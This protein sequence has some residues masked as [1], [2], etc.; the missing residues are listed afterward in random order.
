MTVVY[1]SDCG[2]ER[3]GRPGLLVYS[4]VAPTD[5]CV[6][7]LQS[8]ERQC[9]CVVEHIVMTSAQGLEH[10]QF[11]GPFCRRFAS[12]QVW[13]PPSPWSFPLKLPLT[14]LGVPRGFKYIGLDERDAER[15]G[16][17]DSGPHR[18]FGPEVDIAVLGPVRLDAGPFAEVTIHHRPSRTLIVTDAAVSVPPDPP[19]IN[20]DTAGGRYALLFHARDKN[21]DVMEDNEESRREGWQKIVLF[22]LYFRP[23]ALEILGLLQSV[24][25]AARSDDNSSA[26][27]FGLFP[28]RWKDGQRWR[29]SFDEVC[30]TT[31]GRKLIVAPILQTLVLNRDKDVI[32]RWLREVTRFG[33]RR[34]IAQHYANSIDAGP[35]DLAAAFSYIREDVNGWEMLRRA[36][37]EM[38]T[39]AVKVSRRRKDSGSDGTASRAARRTTAG[40][41]VF[42]SRVNLP[43][44]DMR[45]LL[46][47]GELVN[48]SQD[49]DSR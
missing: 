34:V 8:L 10:K 4:P 39:S 16:L 21:G 36:G 38:L 11:V 33:F 48:G 5:E 41:A 43:A 17:R 49:D 37:K 44:D 14:W 24:V 12:A 30:N 25:E 45:L 9:G 7:M 13:V 47:V 42:T 40:G 19:R 22:S 15:T 46:D 18:P 23:A 32:V 3:G 28:W 35:Q 27:F 29:E 1:L 2:V 6:R 26:N 31:P 20:A